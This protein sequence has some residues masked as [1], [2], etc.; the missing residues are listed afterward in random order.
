MKFEQ[1]ADQRHESTRILCIFPT[2][3]N[4]R[5]ELSCKIEYKQCQD[6][7]LSQVVGKIGNSSN[8]VIINLSVNLK[9]KTYCYTITASN[10]SY[11]ILIEDILI[12]SKSIVIVTLYS[13]CQEQIRAMKNVITCR[14]TRWFSKY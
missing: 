1:V 14:C 5:S 4:V 13:Q 2:E 3:T 10:G 11:T 6:Q 7:N 12:S 9:L 8:T